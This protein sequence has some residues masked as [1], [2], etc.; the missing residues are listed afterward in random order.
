MTDLQLTV[1]ADNTHAQL[2]RTA[3]RSWSVEENLSTNTIDDAL[4]VASELFSNAVR[5]S[6]GS[7]ID[8]A[9]RTDDDSVVIETANTGPGFDPTSVPPPDADR[10]GGRGLAISRALGSLVVEQAGSTT[11][12][13]VALPKVRDVSE[14]LNGEIAA[15]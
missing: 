9:V 7:C 1:P 8:V 14:V 12:V 2:V 6:V 3:I 5:A 10:P 11:I 13:R 15:G 4:L